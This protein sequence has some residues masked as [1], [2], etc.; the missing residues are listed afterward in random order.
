[1]PMPMPIS[2]PIIVHITIPIPISGCLLVP[3]P[4]AWAPVEKMKRKM[5]KLKK[6]TGAKGEK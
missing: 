4:E 5:E 1:M 2:V 3:V 6:E